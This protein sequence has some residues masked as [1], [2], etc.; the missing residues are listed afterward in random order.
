M[1]S[2]VSKAYKHI[3]AIVRQMPDYGTLIPGGIHRQ[4]APPS[5]SYP[6]LVMAYA[7]GTDV[8][9]FSGGFV[10][11]GMNLLVKVVDKSNSAETA[12]GAFDAVESALL[13]R[14]GENVTIRPGVDVGAFVTVDR[15]SPFDLPVVENDVIYQQ[16]GRMFRVFVDNVE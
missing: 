4:V 12:Q 3:V 11:S 7:T 10:G 15:L 9:G 1:A 13:A 8:Q 6:H 2:E 16:V 5:A 14:N